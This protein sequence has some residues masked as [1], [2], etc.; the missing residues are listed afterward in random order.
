MKRPFSLLALL[1]LAVTL[2]AC[3]TTDNTNSVNGNTPNANN[4]QRTAPVEAT[5]MD[6]NTNGNSVPSN[7][8]VVQNNNGNQNTGGVNTMNQNS[9][10]A[11]GN[12]NH[13][14]N[15]NNSNKKPKSRPTP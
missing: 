11:N 7:T 14:A 8:G 2:G 10:N 1:T 4:G 5:P 9:H 12:D 3:T 13:N 15:S 6:P